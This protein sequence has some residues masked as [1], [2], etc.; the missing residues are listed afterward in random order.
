MGCSRDTNLSNIQIKPNQVHYNKFHSILFGLN[1]LL[2][3]IFI[4]FSI[5]INSYVSLNLEKPSL[6][7]FV[8]F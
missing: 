1:N 2:Y 3:L 8:D 7:E 4:V 5:I 6:Y